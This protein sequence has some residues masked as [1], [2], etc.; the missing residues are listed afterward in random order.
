MQALLRR[1]CVNWIICGLF[2][3]SVSFFLTSV[4]VAQVQEPA[5]TVPQDPVAE[6]AHKYPGLMAEFGQLLQRIQK[7][8]QTPGP[9]GSSQLLPLLPKSTMFYVAIPN[10]GD[11]SHQMLKIFNEEL[12]RSPDLKAWWHD[13]DMAKQGPQIEDAL[14][15]FYQFS[16]YLGD[17]VVVSGADAGEKAPKVLAVAEIHK[18]GLKDFLVQ[19]LNQLP[20][21]SRPHLQ[22][23]GVEE[24]TTA[25]DI[26]KEEMVILVRPDLV[27]LAADL[28]TLRNFNR[29]VENKSVEFAATEFGQRVAQTYDEGAST[30]AAIDFRS[31]MKDM[32]EADRKNPAF[33]RSG[34]EDV[35]YLVWT[36]RRASGEETS[37]MELSFAGP[38]RG[39][40]S[41]LAAPAAMNSLDFVSP[42][43]GVVI[44]L[45]LKDPAVILEDIRGFA[46][47]SN[48][49]GFATID[50]MESQLQFSLRNDLLRYLGG[51][52]TLEVSIPAKTEPAWNVILSVKDAARVQETLDK[53]LTHMRISTKQFDEDGVTYHAL[54]IPS[55][56]KAAEINYAFVDGYLLI[57]SS[58]EKLQE[59]L[60]LHR[61][62]ESLAKSPKFKATQPSGA[63]QFS[64]MLYE[65]PL[66][67][68]AMS[69]RRFMPGWTPTS[70]QSAATPLVMYGYGDA[71]A[72]REASRSS[73]VDPAII[74]V[75]AAIAI[76]N[77]LRA[78]TAAN[79]S[80]AA[81]SIRTVNTAQLTYATAY[82]QKGYARSLAALGPDPRGPA[83]YSPLHA[84]II[85]GTL[86]N[87]TCTMGVWCAK[88]G[89]KF[90]IKTTCVNLQ[91][92]REYVVIGTPESANSGTK[93]F[94][95][96]SDTVV[97]YQNGAPLS[98]P[99]SAKECQAWE[100]IR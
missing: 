72:M 47:A 63:S 84:G 35:K 4:G 67:M 85:D 27:A 68:A 17:E 55:P 93:N 54:R 79:E 60:R 87:P 69:M 95:S 31:I 5:A 70:G 32:P 50:Q 37:Q 66:A 86:G 49:N 52:L 18:P 8:V 34:F 38:R 36:H 62:G 44:S 58:H 77:L 19:A 30:T 7:E 74:M 53:L 97:H 56:Q 16:Q 82:P 42:N 59:A 89:F 99:I 75:T 78:R 48:P 46:T 23:L 40:A 73:G 80:S 1:L 64:A 92:C 11:A 76:P 61:S 96:T 57:A 81:A 2:V 65:D 15:K 22:V 45:L 13:N 10:Y 91:R 43:P 29:Q 83:I 88:S 28:T 14:E 12:E 41:W 71:T 3:I 39:A 26:G 100:P 24:L 9:R 21:K 33:Q 90:I 6:M 25:K 20:A 98:A 51:E 94:C